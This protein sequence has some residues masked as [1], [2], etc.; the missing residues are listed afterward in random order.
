MLPIEQLRDGALRLSGRHC[1]VV[2]KRLRPSLL[3]TSIRGRDDGELGSR[4]IELVEREQE[5]FQRP[6]QWFIDTRHTVDAAPQ[7]FALWTG[8]LT[9]NARR[10][11]RAHILASQARLQLTLS[12]AQHLS[13]NAAL[14]LHN[15]AASFETALRTLG[16]R[17]GSLPYARFDEEPDVIRR[18]ARTVTCSSYSVSFDPLSRS[19]ML[20]TLAG[21]DCGQLSSEMFDRIAKAIRTSPARFSLMLDVRAVTL[22]STQVSEE[23]TVWID[24]YRDALERVAVLAMPGLLPLVLGIARQRGGLGSLLQ[25]FEEP[26]GFEAVGLR[27]T[28]NFRLDPSI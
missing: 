8:W 21:E 18:T 28:P 9:R 26:A 10:V 7:G 19:M 22:V 12:I 14:I 1:T 4:P 24:A 20:V 3:L 27:L 6:V 25:I 11:E 17:E 23:W 16:V 13:Q 15:E 5:R 2:H